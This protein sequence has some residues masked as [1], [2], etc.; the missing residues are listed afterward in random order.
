MM[1]T[2][3]AKAKRVSVLTLLV[4][5]WLTVSSFGQEPSKAIQFFAKANAGWVDIVAP[6][7]A[8]VDHHAIVF[9]AEA[10]KT[11]DGFEYEPFSEI[12]FVLIVLRDKAS[13]LEGDGKIE[14]YQLA[15]MKF[16]GELRIGNERIE[17]KHWIGQ[18]ESD[19]KIVLDE[20]MTI[21]LQRGQELFNENFSFDAGRLLVADLREN[22]ELT[23]RQNKIELP[24]RRLLDG[25]TN[26]ETR[27]ELEDWIK[28][29]LRT[30]HGMVE[31]PAEKTAGQGDTP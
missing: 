28:N 5:Y 9:F 21:S 30:V 23:V 15:V 11:M 10:K 20:S 12:P 27:Q 25:A 4:L 18:L 24:T 19:K 31:P 3:E 2:A 26:A 22:K 13:G 16:G 1:Q 8:E 17:F 29:T 14:A 6:T 7:V